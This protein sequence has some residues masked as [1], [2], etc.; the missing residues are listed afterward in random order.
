MEAHSERVPLEIL[1]GLTDTGQ[2]DP[3]RVSCIATALR[4]ARNLVGRRA[5]DGR[6]ENPQLG[7][8]WAGAL[9]YLIYCEQ[10][11]SC[12]RPARHSH[13]HRRGKALSDALVWF[14]GFPTDEADDLNELRNRLA[15]DYT[16]RRKHARAPIFALHGGSQEPVLER[17]AQN[18]LVGLPALAPRIETQLNLDLLLLA[19][20]GELLCHHP[21]GLAGVHKRFWMA[22]LGPSDMNGPN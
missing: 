13:R 20:Q 21:D 4:E 5:S 15:H 14:A 9:V 7:A 6:L 1:M 8:T 17:V 3:R 12:F 16:L 22:T 2:V 11:G 10:I 18:V 19:E